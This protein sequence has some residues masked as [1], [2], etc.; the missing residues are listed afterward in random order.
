MISILLPLHNFDAREL[1]RELRRQI[2]ELDLKSAEIIVGDDAS[3]DDFRTLNETLA[4]KLDIQYLYFNPAKGRSGN[5]NHL[6]KL[7]KNENLFFLDAD[8]AI[9]SANFLKNYLEASKNHTVI[10]GGTKYE[11]L[12]DKKFALRYNYG[13]HREQKSAETRNKTPNQAFSSFNF[14][15]QKSIF[16]QIKFDERLKT[17]GHEDTLLGI[18]LQKNSI[19]VHHIDNPLI[20]KGLDSAEVFIRKTE[21]SIKNLLFLLKKYENTEK[22]YENIRIL[23]VYRKISKL[24]LT[25]FF[26]LIFKILKKPILRNLEGT[27]PNIR[28]FD[29]YKL[30]FLLENS[31]NR[32]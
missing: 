20:H 13:I 18:E 31:R 27:S 1:L 26:R 30:G 32:D 19:P 3:R 4:K 23:Q 15:I 2:D 25:F 11:N 16:K 12:S 5:R 17:Y 6:A 21:N 24:G 10:C 14:L 8:A 29:F 7:A 9:D 28:L 22:L